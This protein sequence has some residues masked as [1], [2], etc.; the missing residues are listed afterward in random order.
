MILLDVKAL[1]TLII[2]II[3]I[4][5]RWVRSA[6]HHDYHA[7]SR[8]RMGSISL[9]AFARCERVFF[10]SGPSSAKVEE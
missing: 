3:G 7:N 4:M 10:M 6:Y 2:N 5:I 9:R 1:I 8:L